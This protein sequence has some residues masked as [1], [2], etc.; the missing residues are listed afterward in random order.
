MKMEL[1]H[2]DDLF[3]KF[4]DPWL[5]DELRKRRVLEAT[6]PDMQTIAEWEGLSPEELA[7]IPAAGEAEVRKQI[8]SIVD[9]ATEDW[10]EFLSLSSPVTLDWVDAF[11][12]YYTRDEIAKVIDRSDPSDYTNEY[13]ILCC[14]LGAVLGQCLIDLNQRLF[15]LPDYPYWETP[16]FDPKSG[17]LINVFS[18]AVKKMSEYGVD[19][20]LKAKALKCLEIIDEK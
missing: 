5:D 20:G 11:D 8:Q 7:R 9:A 6:R 13:L 12:R 16:V 17:S 15:W 1:P 14:E 10:A 4:F 19:D 18:W 3:L 2:C